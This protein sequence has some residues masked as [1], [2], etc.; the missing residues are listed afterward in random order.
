MLEGTLHAECKQTVN[1]V[2]FKKTATVQTLACRINMIQFILSS[3]FQTLHNNVSLLIN[4]T[5]TLSY[6]MPEG[7]AGTLNSIALAIDNH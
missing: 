6:I 5:S 2:L 3:L 7:V 1:S 4:P